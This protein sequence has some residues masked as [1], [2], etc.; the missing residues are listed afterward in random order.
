MPCKVTKPSCLPLPTNN[1][2]IMLVFKTKLCFLKSVFFLNKNIKLKYPNLAIIQF[3][4][5]SNPPTFFLF[6]SIFFK[7]NAEK[8]A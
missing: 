5:A 8:F 4:L 7:K 3:P 2:S 6:K 1:S